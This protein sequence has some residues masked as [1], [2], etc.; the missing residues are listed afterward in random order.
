MRCGRCGLTLHR[1]AVQHDH[2]IVFAS[3]CP[4]C[5]GPLVEAISTAAVDP[6]VYLG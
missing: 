3:C 2:T 4:R 1:G 6:S 5:D